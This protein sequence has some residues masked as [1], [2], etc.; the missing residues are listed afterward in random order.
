M[1]NGNEAGMLKAPLITHHYLFWAKEAK[2]VT[3]VEIYE[4]WIPADGVWSLWA[5]PVPFA[6]MA[7][8]GELA[9]SG[10]QPF[11]SAID[12][13]WA[14]GAGANTALIVDLPGLES[15]WTGLALAGRGYRPVPLYNACTGPAEVVPMQ[16][17]MEG[18]RAGAGYLKSLLLPA[19]APPA[20][21]IDAN[22][23]AP[24]RAVLPGVFDNRW[25][26]FP[27]D[28]PSARFLM[29]RGISRAVLI[30]RGKRQAEE[31]LAHVLLRWADAGIAIHAKDV[32]DARP[33]EPINVAKPPWYRAMTYRVREM[34]GLRSASRGGFGR[35]VPKPS[36]HG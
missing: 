23:M 31:D 24:L 20:F 35:E 27:Q 30:Q 13:G 36:S 16:L 26:V 1:S 11:W 10:E 29:D 25:R 15:V 5:R 34:L 18:L 17:I 6:Q 3:P 4:A 12:V 32:A 21:L 28:F 2:F 14:P 19:D 22:R 8:F 7:E 9:Q 33:P